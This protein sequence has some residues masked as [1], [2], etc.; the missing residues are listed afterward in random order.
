MNA[1]RAQEIITSKD[2]IQV[3]YQ[4]QSVWLEGVDQSSNTAR[5]HPEGDPSNS[6]T[7][8]VDKLL[9]NA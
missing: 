3:T 9:E 5:V 4:G 8:A 2:K 6:M 1:S 7:V